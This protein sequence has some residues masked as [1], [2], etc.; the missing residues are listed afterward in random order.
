MRRITLLCAAS[1]ALTWSSAA[2]AQAQHAPGASH[3][4]AGPHEEG[5]A[6]LN[7]VGLFGG[8]TVKRGEPGEATLALEYTRKFR[9]REKTRP[10]WLGAIGEVVL[11]DEK[12]YLL[13]LVAYWQPPHSQAWLRT[14]PGVE[15]TTEESHEAGHGESTETAT[16]FVYRLGGGYTMELG[17]GIGVAPSLDVD[18]V[19]SDVAVVFGFTLEYGF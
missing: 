7:T 6:R 17:G 16:E 8:A 3:E 14:G 18:F 2:P 13:I 12:E 15:W 10:V 1:V 4:T 9:H 11:A 19:R 5:A